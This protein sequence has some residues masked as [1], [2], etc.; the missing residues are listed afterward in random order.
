MISIMDVLAPGGGDGIENE[1]RGTGFLPDGM[2]SGGTERQVE[3]R[4]AATGCQFIFSHFP[5]RFPAAGA[6]AK[7]GGETAPCGANE[8]GLAPRG[9]GGEEGVPLAENLARRKPEIG[10][11]IHPVNPPAA[12]PV[13]AGCQGRQETLAARCSGSPPAS[14]RHAGRRAVAA[15]GTSASEAALRRSCGC[16]LGCPAI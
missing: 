8:G 1:S 14:A 11:G 4:T 2:L 13:Q 16:G 7:A 15:N 12:A 10:A 3:N 9:A 5:P 6:C